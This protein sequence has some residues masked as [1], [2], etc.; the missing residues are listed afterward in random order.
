MLN[1]FPALASDI[2]RQLDSVDRLEREARELLES[3]GS[4][5]VETRAAGSI[6]HDFYTGVEKIFQRI[7]IELDG[8]LPAGPDWHS[9]LLLRMTIEI[10]ERRPAVISEE[11]AKKLAEYLRFRHVF[12]NLYG[13]ELRWDLCR[14]LLANLPPLLNDLRKQLKA[15]R[16]FLSAIE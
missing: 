6:L 2:K 8:G 13:F 7:A 1:R 4:G 5:S 10:D 9:D 3:P 15:F 16:D 12:R 11:L 14:E